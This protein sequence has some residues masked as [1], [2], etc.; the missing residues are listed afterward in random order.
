MHSKYQTEAA[1]AIGAYMADPS[2]HQVALPDHLLEAYGAA[3]KRSEDCYY[4]V[5]RKAYIEYDELVDQA[6]RKFEEAEAPIR[7]KLQA[8]VEGAEQ[9][10][11][12]DCGPIN[13]PFEDKIE[14]LQAKYILQITPFQDQCWI[15][16]A[17]AY[18]RLGNNGSNSA[19]STAISEAIAAYNQAIAPFHAQWNA[20]E[21]LAI[22]ER[23]ALL[24]PLKEP[25]MAFV[26]AAR[27]ECSADLER[28]L[29]EKRD[30]ITTAE[31]AYKAIY[32][33]CEAKRK[34]ETVRRLTAL[35]QY[36]K[37]FYQVQADLQEIGSPA[38]E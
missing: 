19:L 3:K 2:D 35:Q 11:S 18:L 20:A 21:R 26:E 32:E 10:F 13:A 25:H 23:E 16:E 12:S 14:A 8:L 37:V 33:E 5:V 28:L 30:A 24:R 15:A 17:Q 22:E 7:A 4:D 36:R 34:V 1:Q 29:K 9:K 31:N 38:G 27:A 6:K